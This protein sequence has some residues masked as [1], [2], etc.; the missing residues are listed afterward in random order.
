MRL[1]RKRAI[2]ATDLANQA[3][4]GEVSHECGV[5][6]DSLYSKFLASGVKYERY[7]MV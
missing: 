4:W 1:V 3:G 5:V 2:K 6:W 7:R